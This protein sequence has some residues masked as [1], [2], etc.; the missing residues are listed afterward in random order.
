M[1]LVHPLGPSVALDDLE[2]T[3]VVPK[4]PLPMP[5]TSTELTS[6][7]Q[8]HTYVWCCPLSGLQPKLWTFEEF[9]KESA[10]KWVGP[11]SESNTDYTEVDRRRAMEGTIVHTDSEAQPNDHPSTTVV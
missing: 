8:V 9:V 3:G 7:L 5:P 10:W 6:P 4:D 11:A 2:A 1:V